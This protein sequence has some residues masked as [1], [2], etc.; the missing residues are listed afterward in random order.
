[1]CDAGF[2]RESEKHIHFLKQEMDAPQN[3]DMRQKM[4]LPGKL[5]RPFLS[6]LKLP[7]G[8]VCANDYI[9]FG[10]YEA[11]IDLGLKIGRDLMVTGF[12][13]LPF[14]A[15]CAATTAAPSFSVPLPEPIPAAPA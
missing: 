14:A 10:V 1:M 2:I 6:G 4:L 9:A 3:W 15:R 13:A 7:A 11:A 12:S 5:I 8:I